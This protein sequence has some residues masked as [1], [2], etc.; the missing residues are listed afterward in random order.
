MKYLKNA[1]YTAITFE[2]IHNNRIAG[3]KNVIITFDDGYIDNYWI[4]FPILKVFG[5]KAVIFLVTGAK[6]NEWGIAEGEPSLQMM[7]PEM[8]LEMSNYGI[9]FGG[10]TVTHADLTRID[11]KQAENEIAGCKADLEKFFQKPVLSFAYPYGAVTPDIKR[12]TAE[13]G[14]LF[15]I[16]TRSGPDDLFED[17]FQIKRKEINPRTTLFSFRRKVGLHS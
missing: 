9:E 10:H 3:D 6:T 7:N 2:D 14:Y 1:G 13:S 4:A 11:P 5:F 16:A 8:L 15:G 12:I 17:P